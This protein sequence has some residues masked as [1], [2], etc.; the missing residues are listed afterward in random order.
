MQI[1]MIQNAFGS[2]NESGNATK[3]YK[4]GEIISC[5]TEWQKT[6][7]QIFVSEGF[8]MELKI[9]EPTEKKASKKVAKKKA[10]KKK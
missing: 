2:A 10:T 3:E 8:A 1:K 6:L 9:S 7:A 4:D 5:D